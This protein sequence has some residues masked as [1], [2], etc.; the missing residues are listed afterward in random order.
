MLSGKFAAVSIYTVICLL[1]GDNILLHGFWETK[2]QVLYQGSLLW[3]ANSASD[4]WPSWVWSGFLVRGLNTYNY[5]DVT[6]QKI[7]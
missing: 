1:S 6:D 4:I 5:T 3:L 2:P 7:L